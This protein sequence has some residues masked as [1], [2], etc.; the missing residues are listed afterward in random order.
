V[1]EICLYVGI[2]FAALYSTKELSDKYIFW[3][4]YYI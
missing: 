2:W 1:E 4:E 3:M